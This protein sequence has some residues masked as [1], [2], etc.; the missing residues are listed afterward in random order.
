MM[1]SRWRGSTGRLPSTGL[2]AAA[3]GLPTCWTTHSPA[4]ARYGACWCRRFHRRRILRRRLCS[5]RK[6]PITVISS[7]ANTIKVL[8]LPRPKSAPF[9]VLGKSTRA[10]FY[11]FV[12]GTKLRKRF[13]R[14]V[15]AS[16][17]LQGLPPQPTP[18]QDARRAR[19]SNARDQQASLI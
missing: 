10:K 7:K 8:L 18:R 13:F 14:R 4:L 1:L 2:E 5:R 11:K 16:L 15:H 6:Q 19:A 3:C 9:C 17:S 12:H